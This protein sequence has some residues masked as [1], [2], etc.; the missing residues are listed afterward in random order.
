MPKQRFAIIDK[1][2]KPTHV[3]RNTESTKAASRKALLPVRSATTTEITLELPD[4]KHPF[5]NLETQ[6]GAFDQCKK[7]SAAYTKE[8]RRLGFEADQVKVTDCDK[9]Y[10]EPA[11]KWRKMPRYT[12]THYLTRVKGDDGKMYYVD[13]T[14]RQF[15]A[16]ADY[17]LITPAE[18]VESAWREVYTVG[19]DGMIGRA[20]SVR[21]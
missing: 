12:W 7:V 2:G 17:P 14:A 5:S 1:N 21:Y 6:E 9:Y 19:S 11:Q 3:W 15:D 8:L 4:W 18:D 10:P 16:M 20:I 13:Y